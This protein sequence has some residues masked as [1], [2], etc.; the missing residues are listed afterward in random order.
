[1]HG[2]GE[3]DVL[4]P[5][6]DVEL[7]DEPLGN[8]GGEREEIVELDEGREVVTCQP[9]G[10]EESEELVREDESDSVRKSDS[11][12]CFRCLGSD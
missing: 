2:T 7:R 4:V 3:D 12:D 9:S 11:F 10:D 6:R 8:E 1:M 5:R